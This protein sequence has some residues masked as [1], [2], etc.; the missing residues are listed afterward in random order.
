[1]KALLPTPLFI[2]DHISS[3]SFIDHLAD[4]AYHVVLMD[5]EQN[6]AG[7]QL[8]TFQSNAID[9]KSLLKT[10]PVRFLLPSE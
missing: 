3:H 1:M 6:S 9:P 5:P 10:R 8:A 4:E 7:G 2:D